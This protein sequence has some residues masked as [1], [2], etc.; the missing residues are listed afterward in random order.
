MEC[1]TFPPLPVRT[2]RAELLFRPG[3]ITCVRIITEHRGRITDLCT[4]TG[5]TG[6]MKRAWLP[7]GIGILPGALAGWAYW[8][9]WGCTNGCTITGSPINSTL[10]GA[11]MGVLLLH[12]FRPGAKT[13]QPNNKN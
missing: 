6:T 12:T 2:Q 9:W 7:A 1:R 13:Q 4:A 10:Y 5:T 11:L 3:K 8:Y